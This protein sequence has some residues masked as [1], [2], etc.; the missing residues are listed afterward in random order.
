[1]FFTGYWPTDDWDKIIATKGERKIH[2]NEHGIT[3]ECPKNG[4]VSFDVCKECRCF[5]ESIKDNEG[6]I[7]NCDC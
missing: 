1:M 6:F 3:I 2:F 4:K 7:V 5:K